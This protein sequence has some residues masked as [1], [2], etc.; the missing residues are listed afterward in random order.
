MFVV[1]LYKAMSLNLF[2]RAKE[3]TNRSSQA[4]AIGDIGY[5]FRQTRDQQ[6]L[7]VLRS[8]VMDVT[9][10]QENRWLA[11]LFALEVAN[12]PVEQMPRNTIYNGFRVPEDFDLK[13]IES[14]S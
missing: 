7:D 12:T 13:L 2:T 9:A 4:D 10:S 8:V 11:Y 5:L 3:N 6:A 1:E 14:S